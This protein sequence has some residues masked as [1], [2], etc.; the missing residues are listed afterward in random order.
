V[1]PTTNSG[2]R[3]LAYLTVLFFDERFNF[4]EAQDGGAYQQQVASS[5]GSNGASL[6]I[7]GVKAP[8]NGYSFIYVSNQS[9][10]DVY[11]DN[12]VVSIEQGNIIEEN[13]YYSYGLKITAISS[14]R[15]PNSYQ[16]YLENKNLFNDKEL[17]DEGDLN[18]YDYGFR[19]YDPQIGRFMQ[20]DPLA[21]KFSFY[22]PYQYAGCEPIANVDLDG[23]E[24][25]AVHKAVNKLLSEGV[26]NVSRQVVQSGLYAGKWSVSGVKNG[27]GIAIVISS[28]GKLM[29]NL[30][31]AVTVFNIAT[32][33]LSVTLNAANSNS[34]DMQGYF[35]IPGK[36]RAALYNYSR[37]L[38]DVSNDWHSLNFWSKDIYQPVQGG[39]INH[40]TGQMIGNPT[41]IEM[42]D[43]PEAL[44]G[45]GAGS[46]TRKLV[47]GS[48]KLIAGKVKNQI[49]NPAINITRNGLAHTLER[50][51]MN[52][53][54]K[55]ANKSKFF[56]AS[57][58]ESL[59][60]QG[61]QMPM[62]R[63]ANGNFSRIV[64]AGRNIGIDNAT[65]N[66]TSIYTIITNGKGELITSFPGIPK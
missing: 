9:N 39:R 63:Q 14:K 36:E 11:F 47:V 7:S 46:V 13:H 48:S 22:T 38:S 2:T 58:V 8:K 21:D 35:N 53:M 42:T 30:S 18:W 44:L 5:V 60:Q 12:L 61:T 57:E 4:I 16:G 40:S 27:V 31:A 45:A 29:E 24:P 25:K 50:H 17:F 15:I 41:S 51:T 26:K 56:N 3:P 10:Q 32:K 62:I 20:L 37:A 33:T 59:I 52:G 28:T 34:G 1:Q 55:W 64:N 19:H 54:S 65:G 43:G 23:L 6:T 49:L 66:P